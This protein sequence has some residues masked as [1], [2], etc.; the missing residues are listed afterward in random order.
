LLLAFLQHTDP[1]ET[2]HLKGCEVSE[3]SVPVSTSLEIR[4]D[5]K[6]VILLL[7]QSQETRAEWAK[8]LRGSVD[9]EP[10]P[11]PK[12]VKASKG[13]LKMRVKKTL[14]GKVAISGAGKFMAKAA[15]PEE[16]QRLISSLRA[17]LQT[18][19]G[20]GPA[21]EVEDN[22]IKLYV[23]CFC[24]EEDG[25]I[26]MEDFWQMDQPMRLAFA[27]ISKLRDQTM[28]RRPDA[29]AAATEGIKVIQGHLRETETRLTHL[30]TPHLKPHT[31][32]KIGIIFKYIGDPMFLRKAIVA[33]LQGQAQPYNF[34]D[35]EIDNLCSAMDKYLSIHYYQED[36]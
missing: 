13:T 25:Q 21:L 23:K 36:R 35:D 9:K 5:G 26:K 3:T 4:K 19:V 34:L 27:A 29:V 24:L 22:I 20:E 6:V 32:S 1:K 17:L 2:I 30:L 12:R 18:H 14:A 31:I 15:V 11:A 10:R 16:V 8:A 33:P 28:A 7:F